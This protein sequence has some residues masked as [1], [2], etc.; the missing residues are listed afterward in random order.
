MINKILVPVDGSAHSKKA[1]EFACELAKKFDSQLHLLHVVQPPISTQTISIGE[2]A[3]RTSFRHR[4]LEEIGHNLM[5]AA[6]QI[7]TD[8]D[9]I[10]VKTQIE[11]GL[12]AHQIID[13]AKKHDASLIIMGSRGLT[14]LAGLLQGSVSHKV[15]HLAECSCLTIR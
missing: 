4:D 3:I 6:M 13:N 11:A 12:P 14:D 2:P 8:H 7:A 5:E 15:T 1:L 10:N 9:C